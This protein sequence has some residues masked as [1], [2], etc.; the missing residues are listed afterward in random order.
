MCVNKSVR[1]FSALFGSNTTSKDKARNV[2]QL[3]V[4][5]KHEL[6]LLSFSSISDAT[7]SFSFRNKLGE[8]GF[9]PVYKV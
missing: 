7:D 9:G 2:Q 3:I 1:L 6:Q 4:D 5:D 8:G